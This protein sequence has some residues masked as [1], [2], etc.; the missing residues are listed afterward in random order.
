MHEEKNVTK[1]Q[2]IAPACK[3]RTVFIY[4]S[5]LPVQATHQY[6]FRCSRRILR[7]V[8]NNHP[9]FGVPSVNLGRSTNY[10]PSPP[11]ALF[12]AVPMKFVNTITS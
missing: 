3:C 6:A 8:I 4:S 1:G 2:L 7:S 9:T 11:L 10:A 12:A 5:Q